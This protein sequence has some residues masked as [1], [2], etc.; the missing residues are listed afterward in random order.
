MKKKKALA[1]VGALTIAGSSLAACS[2]TDEGKKEGG[3]TSGDK[4]SDKQVLNLT[5]GSDIPAL[6]PTVATDSVSF[7]VLN[8][9]QEGLFRLD[10]NQ[11]ATPGVA[12]SVDVSE[13]G[14]TYTFKLR[15]SKWSDGS[16]VTA[17]DFE[18][19]WK[20]VLDPKS[21]SQY[22][23]IMY[24]I[25][26]AEAYNTGKGK[27]DDVAVKAVDDKTLE[28]KLT[29]P[30]EYFKSL[31]GFGSFMPLKQEFVE[32]Q[33]KNFATKP[34]T[35]LYN[36]P[37]TLSDWKTEVG[38][39]FKK[40]DQYWDKDN[41]K[42]DDINFKIVKEVSTSVNLYEKGD[43]DQVGLTSEFVDQYKDSKEFDT[44][45]DASMYYIQMNFKNELLKNKDIRKA[46]DSGYD[47][48]QMAKVLLNN[49]SIPAY[50]YVP[51]DFAKGPDGKDFRDGN[52][53]FGSYDASSAK[54]S[55]EKGLKEVGKK[56]V[57]LELLSYDDDNS[58]KISEYL[59][60]EWEKNLPG[61]EVTIKQQPFKNKLDL[62]SK[63]E[64]E[65]SFAGWGP[66][67]Q[68]PMTF[69]DMWVTGGP[70]N[71]G[72]YTSDKYDSLIKSAQKEVDA[73]KRWQSLKDAEK[74]LLEDDQAI[75]VM[76]QRG[77]SFLRKPY[78]KG[79]VNHKVGADTSY[80][81]ASIEGK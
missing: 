49:G 57:K 10:E 44:R 29:Q 37:F 74:T 65:L 18:Y 25:D 6:S 48:A 61:L 46:I 71:R 50:Y 23:Y 9:V 55:F 5:S 58:K 75:S 66:D 33:G 16:D 30:A 70:Y 80:K 41:V 32:K 17:K 11:E 4:T 67:Y 21:G 22:A 14:L 43:V 76:Y 15:D 2:T 19:A 3:S 45:L 59:K 60:G 69:L 51:K 36:G 13:D 72:K 38:W 20:R 31:T 42:L 52:E 77:A 79:I 63:G 47:K 56:S 73:A 64:F 27:A 40:N 1:L 12:E 8:N 39:S 54:A 28:V 78:V 34:D 53:G 26:G 81:W 35:F 62:E 68:D 24:I 7:T